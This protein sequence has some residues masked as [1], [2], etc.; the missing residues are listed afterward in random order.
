MTFEDYKKERYALEEKLARDIS[1]LKIK[2]A[3]ENQKYQIGDVLKRK[4]GDAIKVDKVKYGCPF[5]NY[6]PQAHYYGV[7]LTKKGEPRKDK[8]RMCIAQF[9][10]I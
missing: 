2:Y 10:V 6:E 3:K 9:E 7:L 8:A 4:S 1:Q 5:G